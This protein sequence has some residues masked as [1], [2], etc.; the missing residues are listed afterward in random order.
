MGPLAGH[1]VAAALSGGGGREVFASL[2]AIGGLV[3]VLTWIGYRFGPTLLRYGGLGAWWAGWA[4]GSQGGYGYM[5][6]LLILGTLSWAIGTLWY[7]RR[8]DRWPSPISQRLLT[9]ARRPEARR[10]ARR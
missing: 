9:R 5:L 4:C 10:S 6:F 2:V 1:D 7:H 8:R 3:C